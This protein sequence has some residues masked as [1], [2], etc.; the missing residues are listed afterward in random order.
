MPA[1]C[2]LHRSEA[3]GE[4]LDIISGSAAHTPRPDC[5]SWPPYH[6]TSARPTACQRTRRYGQEPAPN[7]H[8]PPKDPQVP[9]IAEH[10]APAEAALRSQRCPV[11]VVADCRNRPARCTTG[12]ICFQSRARH[13]LQQGPADHVRGVVAGPCIRCRCPSLRRTWRPSAR[14]GGRTRPCPPAPRSGKPPARSAVRALWIRKLIEMNRPPTG[15]SRRA[16]AV[17]IG[18][19]FPVAGQP[20]HEFLHRG[21]G[22]RDPA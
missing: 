17:R 5:A 11:H 12:S 15:S 6:P 21:S 8:G 9:C 22:R 19:F 13:E 3:V 7:R 20:G 14:R 16:A 1:R 4:H 18:Q 2:T 10:P